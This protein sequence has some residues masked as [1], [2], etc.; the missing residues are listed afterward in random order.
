MTEPVLSAN[1]RLKRAYDRAEPGDGVRILVDRL[2]PRG[3][4][5][6]DAALD[7]WIKDIA[8]ST[9]LRQWFAHRSERW[10]EFK[11]RY[12][13]EL[14]AQPQVLAPLRDALAA[15]PVTLVYGARDTEHNQAVVLRDYLLAHPR[16]TP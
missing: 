11:Q 5:K 8:P 12:W 9:E 14:A 13:H 7:D 10:D 1:L 3:V 15:G 16:R 2:W 6:E 4:S